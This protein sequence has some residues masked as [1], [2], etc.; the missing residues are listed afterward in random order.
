MRWRS[1]WD[2]GL[3]AGSA[4]PALVFGVAFGN[5]FQGVPFHFDDSMRSF[6]TGSFWALLNPMALLFGVVS[7]AL[8][9]MQ[10]A[11]FLA[12]RT[13]GALQAAK[14]YTVGYGSLTIR[15]GF[16]IWKNT[17]GSPRLP[18]IP[19]SADAPIRSYSALPNTIMLI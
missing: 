13:E 1:A 6:Y 9:T 18:I 17:Y 19:S 5:L 7:L 11:T 15:E 14:R 2:W 3:F 4:V 10:G 12:H 8:L 16:N